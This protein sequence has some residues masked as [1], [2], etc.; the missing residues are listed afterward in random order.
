[1]KL[2]I[3]ERGG[4]VGTLSLVEK[5]EKT[6]VSAQAVCGKKGVYRLV[7]WG[8]GGK[9]SLGL[10]EQQGEF[11]VLHRTILGIKAVGVPGWA[12]AELVYAFPREQPWKE[13]SLR[14]VGE[15]SYRFRI[16]E[17]GYQAAFPYEETEPFP[18]VDRFCFAAVRQEGGRLWVVYSFDKNFAPVF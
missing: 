16:T 2:R 4:Q 1:M 14:P 5:G 18:L 11:L 8:N 10:M 7:L 6:A 12:E 3:L 15:G 9:L 17:K 13:C